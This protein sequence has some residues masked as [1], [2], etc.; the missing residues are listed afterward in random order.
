MSDLL[1][2]ASLVM[3]PSGYAEDKVYSAVPTDGSGDLSFTRASNGTRINSAGL[4][5]VCPWNMVENSENFGAV[6]AQIAGI[7]ITANSTT[8]PNGTTTADT[9]D[10]QSV[11][12]F[13]SI[14]QTFVYVAGVYT[15]SIYIKK[16][17]GSLTHYVGLEMCSKGSYLI[18]NTTTGTYAEDGGPNYTVNVE[19]V[20]DYWRVS[21]TTSTTGG[22]Q[23]IGVWPAISSN[24]S[25]I[26]SGATGS[27]VFWGAQ[28]NIGS[29]AKPYFPTTD[30]LN[31]PRLTYQNGGGGCP[32]LLLE[33]QSTNQLTYS[34]QFDNAAWI[35]E[36][37]TVTANATTSPDG[38]TNADKL[39]ANT[40]STDHSI[41]QSNAVFT[42]ASVSFSAYAKASDYNYIFLGKNNS[43]ASD[44]VFFDLTNGTISQNT[45]ALT[46]SIQSVGN[47]WYRC[48]VSSTSWPTPHPIICLSEN[49]TSF[50]FAGDSSKGVFVWGGQAEISSYPT[51]Y[52]PTTS[53]SATRVAD[54]PVN[55]ST[56]QTLTNFTLFWDGLIFENGQNMFFGSGNSAWYIDIDGSIG[57]IVLDLASGRIYNATSA[58]ITTN[59]RFKLAVKRSAGVVDAFV[60]GTKLT[61][62]FQVTDT[63]SLT[64]SSIT[65]G[66]SSTYYPKMKV[67]EICAFQSA[68]SDSD[69]QALTT[70]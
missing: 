40:S 39:I 10:D 50:N 2:S 18:F 22:S 32:S 47:G 56:T 57:R 35:K 24:G 23:N 36:D 44:G 8:A 33:K 46:A 42:G 29:T 60:N 64:L 54:A 65:W 62:S 11:G 70:I 53:A 12:A 58:G 19:N 13:S 34:E 4:V 37:L 38:T 43:I 55:L 26:S 45:S 16:T 20:G 67:N 1:N 5:E 63:T 51:S 3:I 61:P 27:N 68:L 59:Q 21:I 17:S 9:L 31:V 28:L 25:T 69:C 49:G 30:R 14:Q 7:T 41:Y 15:F 48:I 6:W 52:I 66:F